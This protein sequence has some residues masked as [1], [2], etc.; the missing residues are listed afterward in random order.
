M[1]FYVVE[2]V[3]TLLASITG[4]GAIVLPLKYL[5]IPFRLFVGLVGSVSIATASVAA[6]VVTLVALVVVMVFMSRFVFLDRVKKCR[7]VC[8]MLC[9][10]MMLRSLLVAFC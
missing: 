3:L 1:A 10:F 5:L 9:A 2:I 4:M 7:G 8:V 6:D